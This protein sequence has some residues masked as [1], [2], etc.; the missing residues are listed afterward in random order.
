MGKTALATTI[1]YNASKYFQETDK[2]EDKGI[3]EE[4]KEVDGDQ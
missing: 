1:A 3:K 2:E 4:I